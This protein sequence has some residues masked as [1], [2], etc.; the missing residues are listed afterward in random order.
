MPHTA[1][2]PSESRAT[3]D[4]HHV[5]AKLVAHQGYQAGGAHPSL[6]HH[7]AA[8]RTKWGREGEE[9]GSRGKR[10]KWVVRNINGTRLALCPGRPCL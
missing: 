2:Q 3:A 1:Q 4:L 5:V 7:V 10:W 6:A 8:E 9:Q